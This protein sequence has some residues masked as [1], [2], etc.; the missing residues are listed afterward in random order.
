MLSL[1]CDLWSLQNGHYRKQQNLS[2]WVLKKKSF[3]WCHWKD[4]FTLGRHICKISIAEQIFGEVSLLSPGLWSLQNRHT[5][6]QQNLSYCSPTEKLFPWCHWK[7]LFTEGRN[8]PKISIAEN[9]F[10]K[11]VVIKLL[12]LISPKLA[13]PKTTESGLFES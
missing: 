11:G 2:F 9:F 12:F 4:V 6:K 13:F 1:K 7:Y 5:R 10:W 8:V 3:H